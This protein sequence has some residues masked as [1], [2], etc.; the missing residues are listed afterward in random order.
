MEE[1]VDVIYNRYGKPILRLL[2]DGRFV[3]FLGINLGFLD[4]DNIYNYK[5]KHVG[6]FSEGLIRDHHGH[7]VGFGEHVT[8]L[9]RPFLPFMQY[10]PYAGYVHYEPY[11]PYL[12]YPPYRPYKSYSWSNIPLEEIFN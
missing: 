6:W 8:D 10:K 12:Q 9:T 11:R 7:V 3:T 2:S 4:G 5:G 1:E